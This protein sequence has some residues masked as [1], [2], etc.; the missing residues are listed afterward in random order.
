MFLRKK[1]RV[2]KARFLFN[3]YF[4]DTWA[5]I[6]RKKKLHNKT[7]KRFLSF[8]A[9]YILVNRTSRGLR[10]WRRRWARH[11]R[12]RNSAYL[13]K[14]LFTKHRRK[15]I[16]GLLRRKF[17]Q[18][19]YNYCSHKGVRNNLTT[20]LFRM[21]IR[22]FDFTRIRWLRRGR[23]RF[24]KP[25]PPKKYVYLRRK[26]DY[27]LTP[28]MDI[29]L[30]QYHYG[31]ST[32]K[33]FKYFLERNMSK[34]GGPKLTSFGIEGMLANQLCRSGLVTNIRHGYILV[35][36]GAVVVNKQQVRNPRKVLIVGD[37]F[38]LCF[39]FNKLLLKNLRRRLRMR[40]QTFNVARYLE[41]NLRLMVFRI[42]RL[43]TNLE[44]STIPYFPYYKNPT[45]L[46]AVQYFVRTFKR[47]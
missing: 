18:L 25:R 13:A 35:K 21:W 15:R 23:R 31:F 29:V 9:R 46:G 2:K 38:S 4:I 17:R 8:F 10:R 30:Q 44:L 33:S 24:Y 14:I 32:L 43:P 40:L 41:Y 27:L 11:R 1:L 28:L 45:N 39:P 20:P 5:R 47:A 26:K 12:K 6:I 16:R 34:L 36:S 22:K 19:L 42:Y 7:T 37:T 3:R